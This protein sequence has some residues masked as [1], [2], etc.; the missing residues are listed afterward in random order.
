MRRIVLPQAFRIILP[1]LTNELI[2][3]TKDSSLVYL[4]GLSADQYEL[5]KY[6]RSSLTEY[7]SLS[8]IVVAGLCYLAITLPLSQLS[9]LLERRLSG[10]GGSH[11]R[12]RLREEVVPAH[13]V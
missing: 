8:P 4:L 3:L 6:G 2:L 13:A 10:V 5:A 7:R 11:R 1:P 12:V 9:R